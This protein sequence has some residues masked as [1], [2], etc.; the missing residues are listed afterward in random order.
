MLVLSQRNSGIHFF[1]IGIDSSVPIVF[2]S[3]S[4]GSVWFMLMLDEYFSFSTTASNKQNDAAWWQLDSCQ[5]TGCYLRKR[6]TFQVKTQEFKKNI[7]WLSHPGK[8]IE[9]LYEK[10]YSGQEIVI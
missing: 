8:V 10:K 4:L 3:S 7:N 2:E 9:K 6:V 1:I 5:L